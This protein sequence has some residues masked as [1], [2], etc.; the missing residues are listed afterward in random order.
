MELVFL[1]EAEQE[2]SEAKNSYQAVAVELGRAF[3]DEADR[4]LRQLA[5]FPHSGPPKFS[6]RR[7]VFLQ[8]PY[9]MIYRSYADHILI[10]AITHTSRRP[11]YW[12]PRLVKK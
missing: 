1:P 5:K 3:V 6:C 7:C 8:F 2:L 4:I 9:A 12:R 10:V 11:G